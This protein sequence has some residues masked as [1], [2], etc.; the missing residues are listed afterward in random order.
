[1]AEEFWG[2]ISIAKKDV[3]IYYMQP[4]VI[5]FGFVFPGFTYLA[6]HHPDGQFLQEAIHLSGTA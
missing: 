1:M 6:T 3:R 5:M 2:V 4:P